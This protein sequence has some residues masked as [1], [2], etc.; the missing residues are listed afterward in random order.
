[1][2]ARLSLRAY[3]YGDS[4]YVGVQEFLRKNKD[5]MSKQVKSNSLSLL[6]SKLML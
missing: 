2:S 6:A 4:V 3:D 1:M 5:V